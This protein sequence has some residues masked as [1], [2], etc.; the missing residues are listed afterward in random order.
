MRKTT[1]LLDERALWIML[2]PVIVYFLVFRYLPMAGVLIAFKRFSPFKGFLASPWVGLQYFRQFF[3]SIYFPRVLRNTL[4]IGLFYILFAF[5][6]PI[7]LALLLNELKHRALKKVCQTVTLLPHFVS[8]VVIAGIAVNLLSPSTGAVNAIRGMLGLEPVF[9]LQKPEY[10]WSIY[11]VIRIFKE[12]GYEAIVYL[13]ALAAIDPALYEAA[14]CDGANRIQQAVSITLPSLVPAIA[15]MF[16]V[17]IGNLVSVSFEEVLLLQNSVTLSTAEVISTYVYR[18][19]LIGSD[20]SFATAV[21]LFETA[22]ALVLVTF[23]NRIARRF[24]SEARLW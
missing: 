14:E 22:V 24:R 21:G 9:F 8:F 7:V 19:G 23:S 5:P 10:F 20:Y 6:A 18:R 16:L 17:R 11:T 15:I 3:A 1:G 13:A 2:V 4:M 12:T